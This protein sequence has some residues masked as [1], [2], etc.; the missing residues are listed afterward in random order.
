[1]SDL[2]TALFDTSSDQQCSISLDIGII[3][4]GTIGTGK[5]IIT[6]QAWPL[7]D[8]KSAQVTAD[9]LVEAINAR[10]GVKLRKMS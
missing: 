2:I 4:P 7:P 1:M 5:H 10:L 9:A 3:P 6:I 8:R